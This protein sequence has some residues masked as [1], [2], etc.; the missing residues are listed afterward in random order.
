VAVPG[1]L[2]RLC[3]AGLL[4]VSTARRM[5]PHL[6]SSAA[7]QVSPPKSGSYLLIVLLMMDRLVPETCWGNKTAYLIRIQLV[8]YLHCG[9][10]ARSHEHQICNTD[11]ILAGKQAVPL[12]LKMC[13]CISNGFVEVRRVPSVTLPSCVRCWSKAVGIGLFL[14][15]F[16]QISMLVTFENLCCIIYEYVCSM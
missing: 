11:C 6:P 4:G 15:Y 7:F 13:F 14:P 3:S 9:Y 16:F 5:W 1:K 12:W 2:S 10:D 8:L